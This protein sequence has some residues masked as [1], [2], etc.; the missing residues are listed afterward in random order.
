MLF[1]NVIIQ[2]YKLLLYKLNVI[3]QT[4]KLKNNSNSSGVCVVN[5]FLKSY[6]PG[7]PHKPSLQEQSRVCGKK[8]RM[9]AS[10]LVCLAINCNSLNNFL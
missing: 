8:T 10:F 3:I 2:T 4:Y 1:F 9:L 5:K 6:F 7:I